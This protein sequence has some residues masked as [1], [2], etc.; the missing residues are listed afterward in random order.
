MNE[1]RLMAA[2]GPGCPVCARRNGRP[3]ELCGRCRRELA[4]TV[5]DVVLD[6]LGWTVDELAEA[7][8]I[9]RRTLLRAVRGQPVGPRTARRLAEL[10]GVPASSFRRRGRR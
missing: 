2:F 1:R 10:M 9:A 3:T 6:V 7:S 5:L 4:P 8:G